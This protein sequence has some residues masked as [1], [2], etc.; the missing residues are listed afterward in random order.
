MN[1]ESALQAEPGVIRRELPIPFVMEKYDEHPATEDGAR[2]NYY[3]PFRNDNNPSLDVFMKDGEW[4]YGDFG[5]GS[6]GSS[7]DLIKRF[8]SCSDADAINRARFL[9]AEFVTSDW[10]GPTLSEQTTRIDPVELE[11]LLATGGGPE[12]ATSLLRGLYAEGKHPALNDVEPTWLHERWG[13]VGHPEG[14]VLVP[15]RDLDGMATGAKHRRGSV[16]M[17]LAGSRLGLYGVHR[18]QDDYTPII[19]CEGETDT[20]AMDHVHGRDYY[21]VGTSA[22]RLPDRLIEDLE[23]DGRTVLLAFDGDPAGRKAASDWA[24]ALLGEG[25]VV[26]AMPIPSGKDV[27]SLPSDRI[28][29]LP[30]RAKPFAKAPDAISTRGNSYV[31]VLQNG[32]KELSDWRFEVERVL[33]DDDGA[34]AFEGTLHPHGRTEILQPSDLHSANK[35]ISWASKRGVHWLGNNADAQGL[36]MLLTHESTLA[37][38]GR[39]TSVIGL[40][41]GDYVLPDRSVGDE[42]WSWMPGPGALESLEERVF[43]DTQA[44]PAPAVAALEAAAVD[45]V[46]HPMLAWFAAAPLRPLFERFPILAVSGG[47]GAGKTTLVEKF[48]HGF[49]G[50]DLSLNLTSTT[51]FAV[52]SMMAATNALPVWFDE[53]RPGARKDTKEALDQLL[54]DAYTGQRS[55]RGQVKNNDLTLVETPT[56]VPIVVTGEDN[57]VETSHTDRMVQIRLTRDTQGKLP[58]FDGSIMMQYLSWLNST[59]RSSETPVLVYDEQFS[60]LPD[61]QQENLAVL[62]YGWATLGDFMQD[63]YPEIAE[64]PAADFSMVAEEGEASAQTDPTWDAV[65]WAHETGRIDAVQYRE[66]ELLVAPRSLLAEVKKVGVFQL[67]YANEK[68]LYRLLEE[69]HGGAK[70]RV[71]WTGYNGETRMVRVVAMPYD[72]EDS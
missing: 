43:V 57:F 19:I 42:Q 16:K 12:A 62:R 23:L 11:R 44:P 66:G 27:C 25:A 51:P 36:G 64:W 68:G 37:P 10:S 71:R 72:G 35:L 26:R 6:Q 5:E 1:R 17:N 61:R 65:L 46:S 50:S 34:T 31:R 60:H 15:Y 13:V 9:L 49:G 4:R 52:S 70:K 55:A 63:L 8:D 18:I 29:T 22:G 28:A 32:D 14:G 38:T 48:M 21:V 47:S 69:Q 58:T 59:G 2:L 7:I 20:W 45:R 33:T 67:P 24:N 54:R 41:S 30:E 56:L 3:S 53:Y 39:V 40:H